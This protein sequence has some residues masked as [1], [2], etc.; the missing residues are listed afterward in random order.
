MA[1]LFS[2]SNPLLKCV[3]RIGDDYAFS[4]YF[5]EKPRFLGVALGKSCIRLPPIL[6]LPAFGRIA[7]NV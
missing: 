6:P 7:L 3:P 2:D 4:C 5:N 1:N